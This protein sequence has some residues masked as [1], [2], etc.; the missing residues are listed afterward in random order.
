MRR[1]VTVALLFIVL[2][3][4]TVVGASAQPVY[5][6]AA[7]PPGSPYAKAGEFIGLWLELPFLFVETHRD[8]ESISFVERRLVEFAIVKADALR[9]AV[10]DAES[11]PLRIVLLLRFLDN[12]AL[13]ALI[14]HRDQPDSLVYRVARDVTALRAEFAEGADWFPV[15]IAMHDGAAGFSDG[16]AL[17]APFHPG[18]LQWRRDVAAGRFQS[19]LAPG[20]I[21]VTFPQLNLVTLMA[22]DDWSPERFDALESVNYAIRAT[23]IALV[24]ELAEWGSVW[25][26][27]EVHLDEKGLFS[28][29]MTY[30]GYAQMAAHPSHLRR[31]VTANQE[32]GEIYSLADLFDAER[33]VDVLSARVA[34]DIE[35]D[36]VYSLYGT[37]EGIRP[38]HD[39]YLTP[40]GLVL[41]FQVYDIAPYAYGIP[42]F[43][44]PY[45]ELREI[46]PPTSPLV[47]LLPVGEAE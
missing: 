24:R 3:F 30:S 43:L 26:D 32:T 33:Y 46:I 40:E 23:S 15:A 44:I 45:E 6:I 39:F 12:E 14:T 28:V 11:T 19:S 25:G 31:S 8:A 20:E 36:E 21:D 10:D 13:Y 5:R 22:Q 27:H 37:Y 38:D 47:R 34:K 17:P 18:M 41:Y 29:S 2:V 4:A 7:G 16:D 9:D 42:E 1:S 35:A